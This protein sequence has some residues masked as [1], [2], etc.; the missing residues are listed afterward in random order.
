MALPF[1]S[2]AVFSAVIVGAGLFTASSLSMTAGMVGVA[3]L[4]APVADKPLK[5]S[6]VARMPVVDAE[7]LNV[8]RAVPVKPM[9]PVVVTPS[10][11]VVAP[12]KPVEAELSVQ[13]SFTHQVAVSGANVRTGPKKSYPQVFTLRQGNWVNVSD[14]VQGWVK[15][16]DEDGREGWVYGELLQ[17]NVRTVAAAD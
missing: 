6:Y 10:V 13:P 14:N 1:R 7:A 15:V 8:A 12:P 2:L 4:E 9:K 11:A 5:P 16:T 17:E 3:A